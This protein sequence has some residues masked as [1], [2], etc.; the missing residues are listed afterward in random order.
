MLTFQFRTWGMSL[1]GVDLTILC[2]LSIIILF[3]IRSLVEGTNNFVS[4]KF[5]HAGIVIFVILKTFNADTTE[6]LWN[7]SHIFGVGVTLPNIYHLEIL[8]DGIV[9]FAI[10]KLL[11]IIGSDS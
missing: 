9:V 7:N 4:R 8:E 11:T 6:S 3:V 10:I 1:E 2:L 5:I